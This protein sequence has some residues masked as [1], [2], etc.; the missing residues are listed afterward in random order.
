MRLYWPRPSKPGA[1]R[2]LL[3]G[4]MVSLYFR[5]NALLLAQSYTF[6]KSRFLRLNLQTG[7]LS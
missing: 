3:T 4:I 7:F 6:D 1:G 2:L 5:K